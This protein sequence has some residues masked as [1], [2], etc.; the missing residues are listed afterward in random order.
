MAEFCIH[1]KHGGIC[2][3]TY[4]F[5]NLGAKIQRYRATEIDKYAIKTACHNFPDIEQLG[6]AFQVREQHW[7][8]EGVKWRMKSG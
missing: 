5:C 3:K 1:E 7:A 8:L 2:E 6:D 4:G